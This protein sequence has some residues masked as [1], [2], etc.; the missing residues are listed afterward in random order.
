MKG[1]KENNSVQIETK[2]QKQQNQQEEVKDDSHIEKKLDKKFTRSTVSYGNDIMKRVMKAENIPLSGNSIGAS[3]TSASN[4]DNN[5][6]KVSFNQVGEDR[7][8]SVSFS[9]KKESSPPSNDP[10]EGFRKYANPPPSKRVF[11]SKINLRKQ[12]NLSFN[13]T[14]SSCVVSSSSVFYMFVSIINQ[15]EKKFVEGISLTFRDP[16]FVKKDFIPNVVT[17]FSHLFP[18]R[19]SS[20]SFYLYYQLPIL[21]N[22]SGNEKYQITLEGILF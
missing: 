12:K 11:E 15:S 17:H 13:V 18:I 16:Q 1:K 2:Q 19:N 7:Q 3:R 8:S 21:K 22:T 6:S 5:K 4:D 9:E 14:V 10:F 20:H